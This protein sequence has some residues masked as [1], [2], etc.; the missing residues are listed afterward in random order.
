MDT[1]EIR[2]AILGGETRV[3][4]A[5]AFHR[6]RVAAISRNV[7]EGVDLAAPVSGIV[8]HVIPVGAFDVGARVDINETIYN[9]PDLRPL[10]SPTPYL[11]GRYNLDG[12]FVD[13][14][15]FRQQG[16]GARHY[17]QLF[18]R[19][20]M[21]T[22][23]SRLLHSRGDTILG[24][25]VER[26]LIDDSRRF[27]GL[28]ETLGTTPPIL[29]L[30]TVLGTQGRVI[31]TPGDRYEPEHSVD[32]GTLPLPEI[33]V[34]GFDVDTSQALRPMFDALWQAGG[35]PRSPNYDADGVWQRRAE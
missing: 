33:V 22:F 1:T 7:V 27:L 3:E 2:L 6:E 31:L 13:D 34:N 4:E 11:R 9:H 14:T 10:H 26:T 32:R 21:E 29:I 19:G 17:L 18:R 5:R 20:I 12:I 30:V 16:Q 23:D 25:P 8:L 24:Y 35:Y 15:A 28:M